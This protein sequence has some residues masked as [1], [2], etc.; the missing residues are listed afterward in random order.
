MSRW[1]LRNESN[2][3]FRQVLHRDTIPL[4][5]FK[6]IVVKE[7]SIESLIDK[8]DIIDNELSD[9]LKHIKLPQARMLHRLRLHIEK[10]LSKRIIFHES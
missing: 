4:N 10:E 3:L 5:I 8:R 1:T 9:A 6:K 2:N 7:S